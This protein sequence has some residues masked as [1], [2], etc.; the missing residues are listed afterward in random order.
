M[1]SQPVASS[2]PAPPAAGS[3]PVAVGYGGMLCT[4]ADIRL[5]ATVPGPTEDARPGEWLFGALT[6]HKV[7]LGCAP[8]WIPKPASTPTTVNRTVEAAASARSFGAASFPTAASHPANQSW[9]DTN[10]FYQKFK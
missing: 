4:P 6:A 5:A 3:G 1:T 9:R 8:E 7:K 10:R 2:G